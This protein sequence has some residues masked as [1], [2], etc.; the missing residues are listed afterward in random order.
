VS[1]YLQSALYACLSIR[2]TGGSFKMVEIRLMQLSPYSS[3]IP[4]ALAWWV[5]SRNSNGLP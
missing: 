2:H 1:A 5:S 3:P 4:L